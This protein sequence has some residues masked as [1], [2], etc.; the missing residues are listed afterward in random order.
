MVAKKRK[1]G[2]AKK[3]TARKTVSK[4]S[5]ARKT[6]SKKRVKKQESVLLA[7]DVAPVVKEASNFAKIWVGVGVIAI[8]VVGLLIV[9][10]G[11]GEVVKEGSNVKLHYIGTLEDGTIFD[12]SYEVEPIEFVM[13]EGKVIRGFEEEI[14]GMRVGDKNKISIPSDKAYGEYDPTKIGEY[15]KSKVPDNLEIKVGDAVFLENENGV[16][17]ATILSIEGDVVMLDLNHPLAGK[18]L[19]FEIEILEVV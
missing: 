19:T 8:V 17:V 1:K 7:E 4:K 5:T 12:S 10:G 13:G 14:L 11:S 6:V 16:A 2:I 18:D 3:T 9:L 15:P